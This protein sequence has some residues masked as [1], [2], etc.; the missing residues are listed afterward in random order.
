MGKQNLYEDTQKVPMLFS[1]PGVVRGESE[2]L[3]YVHDIYPTVCEL[4]GTAA[5]D[6]IDGKSLASI[7]AGRREEVRDRLMLA[8]C[9]SQRSIRD[10]QWKLIRLPQINRTLL[11]DLQED[12][13][14][15]RDLS[16][17][18]SKREV[19]GRMTALL[20]AEQARYGDTLPLESDSPVAAE[21][22]PPAQ[23]LPTPYPAGGAAPGE[24]E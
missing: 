23:K 11:F 8:Y 16:G 19:I 21:F 20:A 6:Q 18:P 5:P 12:P 3:V 9:N 13:R 22:I 24:A 2:A 4:A 17:D 1:G 14:E 15:T 10:V 7:M